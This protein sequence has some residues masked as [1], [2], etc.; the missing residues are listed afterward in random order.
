[1]RH[2]RFSG[3]AKLILECDEHPYEL[4]DRVCSP[5]GTTIEGIAALQE[6]GFANAI[7]KQLTEQFEKDKKLESLRKA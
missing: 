1:L 2:R 4:I 5:G 3:C 7:A 6:F